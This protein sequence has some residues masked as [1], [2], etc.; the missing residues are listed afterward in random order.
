MKA[1]Q[2]A[3]LLDYL[4]CAVRH[5]EHDGRTFKSNVAGQKKKRSNFYAPPTK[6]GLAV[7][8]ALE[9]FF[10]K[11]CFQNDFFPVQCCRYGVLYEYSS[12]GFSKKII[13][14]CLKRVFSCFFLVLGFLVVLSV[15]GPS[16]PP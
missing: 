8:A 6:A 12:R 9:N 16:K 13:L 11:K 10:R 7:G 2:L 15:N 14:S 1:A 3:K 4:C 5:G